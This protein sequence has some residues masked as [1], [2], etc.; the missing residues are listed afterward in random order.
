MSL[1]NLRPRRATLQGTQL[2]QRGIATDAPRYPIAE[3]TM[4]ISALENVVRDAAYHPSQPWPCRVLVVDDDEIV[5]ASL[6]ALLRAREFDVESAASGKDALRVMAAT[7]CQILLTDW[8]MPDM[9]GLS[10][11][12]RVRDSG[13]D[14]RV[15]VLMHTVRR[16]EE[17]LLTGLAAGADDYVVKGAPVDELLA[18]LEVGRRITGRPAYKHLHDDRWRPSLTDTSTDTSGDTFTKSRGVRRLTR[19]LAWELARSRRY[20][21]GLA[22]LKCAVDEFQQINDRLGSGAGED[23][24]RALVGRTTSCLHSGNDWLARAAVD[25]YTIVLP[26]ANMNC[27]YRVAQTMRNA[28]LRTASTGAGSV[29]FTVSF[30]LA[31]I[32]PGSG[33]KVLPKAV[34]LLRAAE[35]GLNASRRC[36]GNHVTAAAISSPITIDMGS[37]L[38]GTSAV[39]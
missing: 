31:A 37:L 11:C 36:G 18:R 26:E 15:Y 1:Q 30:G 2:P 14:R 6:S 20:G 28:F 3:Y 4:R 8:Q 10:L 27:A 9:D 32:E 22:V 34:D 39:H 38:E 17:A 23:V 25:E 13:R 7:P 24:M 19:H 12:Q 21:H 5:R 16:G 29:R 35:R 33:G